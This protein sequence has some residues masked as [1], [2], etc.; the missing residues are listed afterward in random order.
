MRIWP[1]RT[2]PRNCSLPWWRRCG[3][4]GPDLLRPGPAPAP[5][6]R[7]GI[8]SHC[9]LDPSL[10]GFAHHAQ[11]RAGPRRFFHVSSGAEQ[12]WPAANSPVTY[13]YLSDF[14]P[15]LYVITCGFGHQV[16][17]AE[18]AGGTAIGTATPTDASHCVPEVANSTFKK[19]TSSLGHSRRDS[20][21][22]RSASPRAH[23]PVIQPPPSGIITTARP[24]ACAD[25]MTAQEVLQD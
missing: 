4:P 7:R 6:L 19:F 13:H 3:M 18:W 17:I 25:R 1:I 20:L 16:Q 2:N 23:R 12:D 21:W 22:P 9:L 5:W 24:G 10:S 8:S 15:A 11:R 14:V